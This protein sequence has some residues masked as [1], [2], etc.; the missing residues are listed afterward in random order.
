MKSVYKYLSYRTETKCGRTDGRTMDGR[1]GG[2]PNICILMCL[3]HT[4][5][6]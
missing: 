5:K 1:T 4:K 3:S 6:T 2:H